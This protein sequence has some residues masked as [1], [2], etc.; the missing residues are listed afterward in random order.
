MPRK[1]A[2][3]NGAFVS[4]ATIF[5]YVGGNPLRYTDPLGLNPVGGAYAGAAGMGS[6]FGP[7]GTVVGGMIGFGVGAWIG[8]NVI[9]PMLQSDG[10]SRPPGAIDAIPGSK[11]VFKVF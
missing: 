7:V 3:A 5:A 4:G 2:C 1:K 9:G 6:V 11:N 8:W 10:S